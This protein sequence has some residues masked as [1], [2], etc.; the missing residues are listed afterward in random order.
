[1]FNIQDLKALFAQQANASNA[2]AMAKYMK[3]HFIFYGVKTPE[4]T[5]LLKEY[6]ASNPL[7]QERDTLRALALALWSDEYRE[8]NY[9][10]FAILNQ[11]AKRPTVEDI[12]FFEQL[13]TIRSWWDSVD[14]LASVIGPA[15]LKLP[16]EVTVQ[17]TE[18]WIES[19]NMWVQR[20][21]IIYQLSYRQRTDEARLFA[22]I[23][24]CMHRKEF[25]L[26]KAIGWALRQY[27][28]TNPQAVIDFIEH[29]PLAP[30]SKRE[31]LRLMKKR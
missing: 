14:S 26:Q 8:I 5:A 9:C 28:R 30:L 12:A 11:L 29:Q 25:F 17:F 7:P 13:I 27:S 18:K 19:P 6:I 1:M 31:A 22:Y 10:A 24:V 4:R 21:A 16:P 2:D 3:N 20:T 15:L 23:Q